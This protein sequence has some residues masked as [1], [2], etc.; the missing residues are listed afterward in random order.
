MEVQITSFGSLT[1]ILGKHLSVRDVCDTNAL[2]N[3][4]NIRY[5]QLKDSKYLI[6][7]NKKMINGNTALE[8]DDNVVLMSP[9]SGG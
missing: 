6:A 7:V 1:D 8:A 2:L 5:P 4:L 3:E 9:F